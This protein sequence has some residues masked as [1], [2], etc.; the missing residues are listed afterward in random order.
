MFETI[1]RK[2]RE[3]MYRM[4]LIKGVKSIA[5]KKEIAMDE[6]HYQRIDMWNALYKGYYE[7]MHKTRYH[8]IQ[9]EKTRRMHTLNMPKV[10]AQEMAG[11]IF[12]ERCEINISSETLSKSIEEIFKKN[13][14]YKRFQDYLEFG[15]ALGGFIPKVYAEKDRSG[16]EILRIGFVT[17]DCFIPVSWKNGHVEEG[18]FVNQSRKGKKYYTLLEWHQWEG[19]E[20]VI[21]NELYESDS[22]NEMGIKVSLEKLYPG[23]EEEVRIKALS[24]PL[25]VY[26]KP[27]IANNFDAHS[28]LGISIY[29]NS[30]DTIKVIDTAFDSFHREFELGKKR[31]IV[32]ATAVK[33]V[34][35]PQTGIP[36]RYFDANDEVYQAFNYEDDGNKIQDISVEIREE[37]HIA[38]IQA[39][40]DILSMQVGFSAGTFTFDGQGVKTATEVVSENS[41]T[42][43]T[44]NSHE[45]IVEE[46]I[47][48]LITSIVEV[49]ELY[50]M[51]SSNEDYEVNIDFDDSIA[52]DRES[53]ADYYLKLKNG[54]IISAKTALIRILDYTEEQATEELELINQERQTRA[55]DI[56]DLFGSDE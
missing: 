56:D 20:Y 41:K 44:K 34:I 46:G 22:L 54:G 12:N 36:H 33:T 6:E 35:D 28:P 2:I 32:P 30:I 42:F 38:A 19:T 14:F 31:I 25:F 18:V 45:T 13:S 29:A 9:G 39:L 17:A 21:T 24:R 23:L 43:R 4:G 48:E 27:N 53:N 51:F 50:K 49:A 5:E 1:F 40:L 8:T 47:K 55:P 26:I 11:L 10:I 7:E 52:E 3:V 15:F 37:E 16:K